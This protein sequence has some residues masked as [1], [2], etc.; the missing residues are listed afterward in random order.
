VAIVES[1]AVET[2]VVRDYLGRLHAAGWGLPP[3]RRDELVGEVT[4]H[5]GEALRAEHEAG[6]HGEA[7]VRNVLE[8]LGPPEEIVRAESEDPRY[9]DRGAPQ[10][11]YAAFAVP[12]HQASATTAYSPASLWGP[13]E[14]G[15][16]LL[17]TLGVLMPVIGLLTGLVLVWV[18]AQW[19]RPQKLFATALGLLPA[20]GLLFLRLTGL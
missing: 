16:V 5:I 3:T 12:V 10:S 19:T 8:R 11:G 2:A 9:D 18:S 7:V 14:I 20:L 13:V 17:L 4:A 15:A 1:D 6:K